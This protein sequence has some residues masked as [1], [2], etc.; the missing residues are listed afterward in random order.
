ML[1]I[2][3][4]IQTLYFIVQNEHIFVLGFILCSLGI[5]YFTRNQIYY[6]LLPM[7]FVHALYLSRRQ[8]RETFFTEADS[9]ENKKLGSAVAMQEEKV[10]TCLTAEEEAVLNRDLTVRP[11]APPKENIDVD[12]EATKMFS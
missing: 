3:V 11:S 6:L 1:W 8:L 2:A 12:L 9:L 7:L 4:L 5:R 10:N